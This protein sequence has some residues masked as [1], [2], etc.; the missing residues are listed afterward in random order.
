MIFIKNRETRDER[1][2]AFIDKIED[3]HSYKPFND[4]CELFDEVRRSL[5]DFLEKNLI[6]Y[7]AYDSQLLLDSSCDDVDIEA[8]EIFFSLCENESLKELKDLKGLDYMLASINA[9]EFDEGDFK[10]NVAGALFFAKDISKFNIPHEVKMVK[11][12]NDEGEGEFKK[13][14]STKSI[15]KLLKEASDFY[16]SSIQYVSHIKGFKRITR[17][18]Y[19]FEAVREAL[20][21]AIAHRDY[22]IDSTPITFYL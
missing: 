5:C 3:E 18:Q 12:Y 7:R 1:I 20:V 13:S 15:L 16:Y 6:N 4:L 10:L 19:P 2:Y 8:V 21:N 22:S 14:T 9:G 17:Y 11:F